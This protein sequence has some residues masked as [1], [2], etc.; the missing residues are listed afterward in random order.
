MDASKPILIAYDG[1]DG[2]KAAIE[3]AGALFPGSRAVVVSVWHSAA[4]AAS[5][6][7]I[8]IPAGVAASAYEQLDGESE[9]Q[10]AEVAGEGTTAAKDAG[11]DASAR[12]VA[13][14][15]QIWATLVAAADAEDVRAVVVGSRGRSAVKS[16]LLGSVA[17]GV[18]HHS[19]RPVVVV[20]A[21]A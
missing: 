4:E 16:A 20:P 1:S 12:A 9:R 19:S 7:V 11:L 2:S 8:A 14:R 5:A 15:G 18:V 21:D 10:A 6:A 13:R 17:N 3:A